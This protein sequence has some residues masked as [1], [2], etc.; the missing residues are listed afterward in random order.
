MS[1]DLEIIK[2]KCDRENF[3]KIVK[4]ENN[5]LFRFIAK[6]VKLFNPK[7]IFV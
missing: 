5:Y 2:D 6:F 3:E 7:S 4:I 1:K